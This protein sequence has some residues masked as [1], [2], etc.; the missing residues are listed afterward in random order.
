MLLMVSLR[1]QYTFVDRN[2]LNTNNLHHPKSP[3]LPPFLG[4]GSN[5]A[6]Q[7]AY[8]LA[9][10]MLEYNAALENEG[11]KPPSLKTYLKTYEH[12]RWRPTFDIF[13]K[14]SFLGYLETGGPNGFYAKFRDVFFKTMG[15]VGV[16]ERV[17]LSAASPKV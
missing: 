9:S 6:V 10:K 11:D 15:V 2:G 12:L 14:S 16:A 4:Q 7:D 5:Q 8:C 13:L 3:A 17:L 1:P